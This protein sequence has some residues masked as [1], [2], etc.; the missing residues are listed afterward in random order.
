MS[1]GASTI[2]MAN[3]RVSDLNSL[4]QQHA[5]TQHIDDHC[6]KQAM[7]WHNRKWLQS[8]KATTSKFFKNTV[9]ISDNV[10][11]QL[12]VGRCVATMLQLAK[13]P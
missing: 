10:K 11:G 9:S 12:L 13:V 8:E 6:R 3:H 1:R 7:S 4:Q 5:C 2:K